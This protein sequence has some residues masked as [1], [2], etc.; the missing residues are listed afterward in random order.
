[1]KIQ[2][3][4][5]IEKYIRENESCTL[6]HLCA[7]FNV[8]ANTMRRDINEL[9]EKGVIKKVYG[10]VVI[11]REGSPN[12]M[13]LSIQIPFSKE[14]DAIAQKAASLVNDNDIILIGSGTTTYNMIRHLKT[15]KNITVVTNNI[16]V[17]MEALS[18]NNFRLVVV[19]GDVYRDTN[20]IVSLE[21]INSLE[22]LNVHKVF[23]GINGLAINSG[24]T[25]S[26]SI[27]AEIKK[28]M[29]KVSSQT[30]ILA[31][32]TKFGVVSLYTFLDFGKV[33]ILITDQQPQQQYIDC[34]NQNKIQLI[35]TTEN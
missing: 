3:I 29:V 5:E 1:M 9:A 10:G 4:Q 15:K 21:A 31:D 33:D 17:I 32:H 35:V 16:L 12:Q 23:L 34:F 20:S 2:R 27:E 7:V 11:D 8:S 25:N 30:I 6:E 24:F 28:M 22:K 18:Y 19:G 13:P 26:S 14:R